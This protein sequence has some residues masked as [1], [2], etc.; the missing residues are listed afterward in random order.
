MKTKKPKTK[1]RTLKLYKVLSYYTFW[2]GSRWSGGYSHFDYTPYFPKGR[3]P[4]EWTPKRFRLVLCSYGWHVTA[5]PR[6]WLQYRSRVFLVETKGRHVG[7]RRDNK[8]AFSQ[9][10]LVREIRRDT[11]EWERVLKNNYQDWRLV[12]RSR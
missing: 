8:Q 2:T 7:H 3:K 12:R 9:I 10:R 1:V 5:C 6:N 11:R 4:G